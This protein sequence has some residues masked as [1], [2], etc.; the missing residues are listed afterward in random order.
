VFCC[1]AWW[2]MRRPRPTALLIWSMIGALLLTWATVGV[3]QDPAYALYADTI[4]PDATGY[5]YAAAL[6]DDMPVT[7]QN[8]PE[9]MDR[10][11]SFS[12]HVH[13][14]PPGL[15]LIYDGLNKLLARLPDL[16]N[17]LGRPLRLWQCQNY[18][19]MENTN[20]EFASAWLGM[21]SPLWAGLTVLPL[22]QLGRR[23]YNDRV[24]RWTVLWW[25]LVP[26]LLVF[27]P[28]PN[29]VYPLF[30]MIAVNWLVKGL[31]HRSGWWVWAAGFVLSLML[32]MNFSVLPLGL[33]CGLIIIGV[34][35]IEDRPAPNVQLWRRWVKLLT[36]FAAGLL[37]VWLLF[38]AIAGVTPWALLQ[39][40]TQ[41]HLSLDRPYVPWLFL[42]LNDFF[43]FTGWPLVILFAV[44][45]WQSGRK[46]WRRQRLVLGDVLTLSLLL[47]IVLID[48]AGVLRGETGRVLLFLAPLILLSAAQTLAG[49]ETARDQRFG[50]GITVLQCVMVLALVITLPISSP[51]LPPPPLQAPTV[52]A[53]P[54]PLRSAQI[55]FGDELHLTG[56][57]GQ[58]EPNTR[59]QPVLALWLEWKA[60]RQIDRP[61]YLSFIPVAPD[62]TAATAATLLQP[63]DQRYPMTCWL[64]QSGALRDR[65]EIPLPASASTGD[66]WVSLSLVDGETGQHLGVGGDEASGD[67]VGLGPF[68]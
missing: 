51:W 48:V 37:P 13:L 24:A 54:L 23:L 20:D 33:V 30:A 12:A 14:S 10:A 7:L 31:Q 4:G 11:G 39:Q 49:A 32:F 9:F 66:W 28:L 17:A 2:F 16:A 67:Q 5:H 55:T 42:H 53:P 3:R 63:F 38:Y 50:W 68:R 64:P 40:M 57:G 58:V 45:A 46:L 19:L 44:S 36:I 25:P 65:L 18:R 26:A 52:A 62:H 1:G 35:L 41:G 29:T 59:A 22:Y 61:Y 56:F 8:W 27:A 6:I 15:V 60:N 47:S 34:P 21:L 43:M